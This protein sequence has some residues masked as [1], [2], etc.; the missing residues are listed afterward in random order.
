[1]AEPRPAILNAIDAADRKRRRWFQ[2]QYA[3]VWVVVVGLLLVALWLTHNLDFEWIGTWGPYIIGGTGTTIFVCLVSMALAT[4]LAV[5]GAVARLSGN[6]LASGLAGLYVSLVR[7]TPLL[8]QIYFVYL[9][10]PQFG[11]R[12]DALLAGILAL[13]FNYGAYMTEI[14]R[15]GIQ[16]VPRAQREAAESLGMPERL[17]MRRIVMPQ[18]I[19]IVIPAIGN[20]FVAMIKDSAL[21]STISVTELL[22]RASAVGTRNFRTLQALLIAAAIYWA[23]TIIFSFFQERLERRMARGDR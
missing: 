18:A 15:A 11:I 21:I 10:L 4:L 5:I 9:A 7:G 1:M 23:L 3:A 12:L 19:R 16:A 17:V 13:G 8:V 14:F 6:P 20:D 2:A 22:W